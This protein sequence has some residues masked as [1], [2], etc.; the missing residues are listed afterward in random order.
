MSSAKS[1]ISH[2]LDS[3]SILNSIKP[4]IMQPKQSFLN[5]KIHITGTKTKILVLDDNT[6][7]KTTQ[8][9]ESS[10]QSKKTRTGG[11]TANIVFYS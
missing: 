4:T 10:K 2:V 5:G 8:S 1:T 3:Y 11:H 6:H 9:S 7:I